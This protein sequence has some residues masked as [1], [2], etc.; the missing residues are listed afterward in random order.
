MNVETGT[1]ASQF[2]FWEYIQRIFVAVCSTSTLFCLCHHRLASPSSSFS[3]PMRSLSLLCGECFPTQT[4]LVAPSTF[5]L[6]VRSISLLW[7]ECF[8]TQTVLAAPSTFPLPVRSISLLWG[9]C[10]PTQTVLAAPSTFP[11]L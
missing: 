3:L 2:L 6:P 11:Y 9:E 5:P 8:S 4:V 7:G 1:K 10:F